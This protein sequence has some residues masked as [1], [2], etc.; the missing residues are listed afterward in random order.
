M[1]YKKYPTKSFPDSANLIQIWGIHEEKPLLAYE[2]TV[3]VLREELD[4]SL[5]TKSN[6]LTISLLTKEPQLSADILNAIAHELDVFMRTKRKQ[7][8]LN[9]GNGSREDYKK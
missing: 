7:T 2:K 9:S 4:V 1:I 3:K 8:L 6:I 5:E